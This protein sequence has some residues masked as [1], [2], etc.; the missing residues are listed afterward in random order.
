[1]STF[2]TGQ[3]VAYCPHPGV[4]PERGVITE[5]YATT[6]AHRVRYGDEVISK[7]TPH[8]YLVT[9]EGAEEIVIRA[10]LAGLAAAREV[11]ALLDGLIGDRAGWPEDDRLL[12][13]AT[14]HRGHVARATLDLD[15]A[16]RETMPLLTWAE[17][18]TAVYRD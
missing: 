17:T 10:A 12:R 4:E 9:D 15:D 3:R 13:V 5:A 1:V 6:S 2:R 7:L 11:A 18:G 8:A 14:A 16:I